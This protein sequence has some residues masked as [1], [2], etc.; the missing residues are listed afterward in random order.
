MPQTLTIQLPDEITIDMDET[1]WLQVASSAWL[2]VTENGV[3]ESELIVRQHTDG[4]M[5]VYVMAKNPE[6]KTSASGEMLLP[7]TTDVESSI[8]RVAQ[9]L[10][11]NTQAVQTCVASLRQAISH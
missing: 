10:D 11:L 1:E 8:V 7:G 9:Q 3:V 4:R 2:H 6:G 5:L